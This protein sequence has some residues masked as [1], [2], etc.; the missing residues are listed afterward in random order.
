MIAVGT[1]WEAKARNKF[2]H[3]F[4]GE[5]KKVNESSVMLLILQVD[6]EDEQTKKDF[7]S[8]IVVSKKSLI[9]NVKLK[10]EEEQYFM[11]LNLNTATLLVPAKFGIDGEECLAVT[12][13]GLA[14]SGPVVQRMEKPEYVQLYLDEKNK[15]LFVLPCKQ[16]AEGARS[17]RNKNK[18]GGYRKNW[19][20]SI[21]KK[22]IEIAGY[23][24]NQYRY[25]IYPEL[26]EGYPNAL[27]FDL[28]KAKV[29]SSKK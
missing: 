17:C 12:K 29:S 6:K 15:L 24:L 28:T 3:P 14:L 23:D 20:G 27:G 1:Y 25:H 26:V 16:S 10:K 18:K 11:K 9:K 22:V 21:I 13:S 19:T 5:I 8:Q 2:K 7:N 4:T